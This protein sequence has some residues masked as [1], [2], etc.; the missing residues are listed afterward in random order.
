MSRAT[1][2][3]KARSRCVTAATRERNRRRSALGPT[4][5][6]TLRPLLPGPLG[7]FGCQAFGAVA[8]GLEHRAQLLV[9]LIAQGFEGECDA[10][11]ELLAPERIPLAA[12]HPPGQLDELASGQLLGQLDVDLAIGLQGLGCI[13]PTARSREVCEQRRPAPE[14]GAVARGRS[15]R[16]AG[17]H[18]ALVSAVERAQQEEM[19]RDRVHRPPHQEVEA[20]LPDLRGGDS[21][22]VIENRHTDGAAARLPIHH[23]RLERVASG[24]DEETRG[25]FVLE[26]PREVRT[27]PAVLDSELSQHLTDVLELAVIDHQRGHRHGCPSFVFVPIN[28]VAAFSRG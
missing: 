20:P 7:V 12:H 11:R 4:G 19:E 10:V 25:G 1:K 21:R 9:D 23:L 17:G 28:R 15:D 14:R 13:E 16:D 6:R 27:D 8:P 24:R 3:R 18:P 22:L 2:V 26:A 5:A